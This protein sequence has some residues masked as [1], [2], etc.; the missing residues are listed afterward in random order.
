MALEI[1]GSGSA[2]PHERALVV[3][4]AAAMVVWVALLTFV[5]VSSNDFWLQ[6][7]V[8][9]LIV[10]SG[11]IPRT[12]LFPFTWAKDYPFNAHEWLPSIVFHLLD[13][14]IG[15]EAM[16]FVQGGLGL[17]QFALCV[18]LA[19]SLSA[20]VPASLL[21]AGIA[22]L[23]ANYRYHLRPEIFALVLFV[24]L[25]RVMVEHQQRGRRSV[26]LWTVPIAI[27]W[28]NSH[29]SFLLGPIIAGLFAVGEAGERL[30][31][32][33]PA[34]P[35]ACWMDAWH[36]AAPYVATAFAMALLSLLNPLGIGL[37]HF[38]FELSG[39]EV[40]KTF[41]HEW[42]PTLSAR[43]V[44]E[45]EFWIFVVATAATLSLAVVR[46]RYLKLSDV[47]LLAAFGWLAM[48]GTR[49]ITWFGFAALI[50]CARLASAGP[51]D[52]ARR[53]LL[54]AAVACTAAIGIGVALKFGNVWGAYPFS[55]PSHRFT[56]PMIE[57]LSRPEMKGNVL[58]T[59]ELGAELIYRA[60]PRLRPSIDSRSDSY[61]DQYFIMHEHLMIEEPLLK[62]FLS[63]FD[64]RYMLLLPRDYQRV[65]KLRVVRDHWLVEFSDH[66]MV[67]LVR[68][69]LFDAGAQNRAIQQRRP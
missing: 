41:I 48:Q 52:A 59:Y 47:L 3:L 19:R 38:A 54:L 14:A 33:S 50:P 67:L 62:E 44:R 55:A 13:R 5:P 31:G 9:Q 30:R 35:S 63:D 58:N 2:T 15:H 51:G 65:S 23:V 10:E 29:G 40:A 17:I 34:S 69:E 64:V 36:A 20:S 26:L 53:R 43:F 7:R 27:V 32:R 60:Y 49:Y 28:A 1:N 8:G 11:A 12:L 39:S 21:L 24:L 25:L 45:P 22:M 68:K 46:R 37:F 66:K 16:L 6:A 61:G 57:R 42:S 18:T 4:A 56:E